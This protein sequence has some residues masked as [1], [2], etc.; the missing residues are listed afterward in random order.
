MKK[1]FKSLSMLTLT[2]SLLALSACGA[3]P[4]VSSTPTP[5][6]QT[7]TPSATAS[8]TPEATPEAS[9]EPA[10]PR[11]IVDANGV[12]VVI[13]QQPQRIAVG[14]F[15]FLEHWYALDMPPAAAS[16]SDDLLSNWESLKPYASKA[17]VVDLGY[18]VNL[19]LLLD[20]APDVIIAST[21]HNDE[22]YEEMAKVA[23]VVS[24]STAA[25]ADDWRAALRSFA[26]VVGREEKAEEF[27]SGVEE[28]ARAAKEK[29]VNE[30]SDKT[31][32]YLVITDLNTFGAYNKKTM[33]AFYDKDTGLG[34]NAPVGYPEGDGTGHSEN[35][36]LEGLATLNPD[37]IFVRGDSASDTEEK[38]LEELSANSV[39]SS[40]SAVKNGKVFILDR[41]AFSGGPIAV[42]YGL[43]TVIEVL[44][45]P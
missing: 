21:P 38:Q 35:F 24:F 41:S 6:A 18:P 22:V 3:S 32:A 16:N 4:A 19:E 37:Y 39:W 43:N 45:N 8:A 28:R 30:Y 17:E 1:P 15:R 29:F 42:E 14:L 23:P 40:L 10:F 36:T 34:L 26:E 12:E 11:T 5:E 2:A 25:V 20:V 9:E 33:S 31:F 27:I 13:E 7:A 44:S